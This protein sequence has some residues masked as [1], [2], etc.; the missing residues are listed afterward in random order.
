MRLGTGMWS[1]H[2][3][4]SSGQGA[5][6]GPQEGRSRLAVGSGRLLGRACA[7]DPDLDPNGFRRVGGKGWEI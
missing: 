7:L 2:V 6:L 1:Y 4:P 5:D 3:S